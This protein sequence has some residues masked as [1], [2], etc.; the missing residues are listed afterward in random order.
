MIPQKIPPSV[1]LLF[2]LLAGF[3][4]PSFG[5]ALGDGSEGSPAISGVIN[6]Y[7]PLLQS[8]LSCT[9][10]IS[11][12][13]ATLFHAGDL[14]LI[15]Q[16]QGAE[17]DGS[18]TSSYG[19][20]VDYAA[21]GNYEYS[22]VKTVIGNTTLELERPLLRVYD[23][24]GKVQVIRVPQYD[25]PV[26]SGILTCQPW[27]GSTGGVL[28]LDATG[29]I[30]LQAGMDVS[31]SGFRGAQ[32]ISGPDGIIDTSYVSETPSLI[33]NAPKGE[34]IAFYGIDPFTSGKGAPANGGGGG[35]SHTAGAAGGSNSGCGGNGGWGYPLTTYYQLSQGL[36]GHPLVYSAA[37]N[38]IFMGGGGGAGSSHANQ[39]TAGGN[40][41]G[42]ILVT[43]NT[44]TA[45]AQYLEAYGDSSL[46]GG[47]P[48]H[49]DGIGGA[50]AGGTVLLSLTGISGTV[51]VNVYGGNGGSP[52]LLGAGPGGGGGGG[53]CWTNSPSLSGS[54]SLNAAGG[55]SG[56]ALGNVF[57]AGDG[58]AGNQ[59]ND[60]VVPYNTTG[61][62]VLADF[63]VVPSTPIGT[64]IGLAN[65]SSA[66]STYL[67]SMGDGE[68]DTAFSPTHTYHSPGV[69]TIT[70]IV[71]DQFNCSD[72]S[73]QTIVT[74][75]GNVF[76]PNNDGKN[77]Y[78][79]FPNFDPGT[80]SL[81]MQVFDRWGILVFE[82]SD[83]KIRW[84]G[85]VNGKKLA[86]GTY[87]YVLEIN[88]KTNGQTVIKKDTVTLLRSRN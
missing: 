5:Q 57:G 38:K 82:A 78:F 74:N 21:A 60:L 13:D 3:H 85:T 45:N 76:T 48:T 65:N 40:G 27:N 73:T 12:G 84:D 26:V 46:S 50:G 18:N 43:G 44:M 15:I 61:V 37:D 41:G 52:S 7:T 36:G 2:S 25:S 6:A 16:M 1:L 71:T 59:L 19:T 17:I 68:T 51:N 32:I 39:G 69:Y 56:T 77:D 75:M 81:H 34:G 79:S 29:S 11:V 10:K 86:E 23:I 24:F 87:Y 70:L 49:A 28:A 20:I 63:T 66:A 8:A 64:T 4:G 67:W 35:N 55:I 9:Q 47:S 83:D 80:Y 72:T 33:G 53:L 58:C 14:I 88:N 30:D 62:G 54:V 22:K 31:K 42:I